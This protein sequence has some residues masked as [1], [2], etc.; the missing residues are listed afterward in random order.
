MT[1]RITVDTSC[2]CGASFMAEYTAGF[3]PTE[4]TRWLRTHE[5]HG[6]CGEG[7]A[8]AQAQGVNPALA[9]ARGER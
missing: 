8:L 3:E 2:S 4:L 1:A 6:G 7:P 5:Q 9:E